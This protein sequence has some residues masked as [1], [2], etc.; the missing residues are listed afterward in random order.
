M[1]VRKRNGKLEAVNFNKTQQRIKKLLYGLKI[2]RDAATVIAQKVIQGLYDGVTTKE[3]DQ[4]AAETAASMIVQHPDYSY[5]GARIL[6]TSLKKEV[7]PT[8]SEATQ[9]IVDNYVNPKGKKQKLFN[10]T[11]LKFVETHKEVLDSAINHELDDAFTY[12]GVLTLMK[13]YLLKVNKVISETPQYMLMREAICVAGLNGGTIEEVI[14]TYNVLSERYYTHATPTL[15]NSG[16][17]KQQ[18]SSCFLLGME[19]SIK[20]IYKTLGNA[21]EISQHAGGIGIHVHNIRS[22]GEYIFGTMGTS[23][24]LV[25]MLKNYND[26]AVYVNQGGK[27]KGSFA[28]YLE[29]HHPDIFE[30]LELGLFNGKEEMRAR[31]LFFAIWGNDLFFER[32][33]NDGNYSL[34]PVVE[35]SDLI[36]LYGDEFR[37]R[38][39]YYESQGIAVRT[40]KAREIWHK[41]TDLLLER[42]MP[43]ILNKDQ[44]NEKSNQKNIGTIR[45]SNLCAEIIE[46]S[47]H[48]EHAV[49]NLASI[50]LSRFVENGKFD[51]EKL[52]EISNLATRNL[53]NVIDVNYYPTEETRISNLK[54]RPIGLGVQGLADVFAMLGFAFDSPEAKKLN[55]EIFETI[56]FGSLEASNQLAQETGLTYDGYDGSPI[57]QG[58]FQ[59]D[60]WQDRQV[61]PNGK[62]GFEIVSSKPIEL[63]GMWDFEALRENIKKY[64]VRNSLNIALMPTASTSQILGNNECFEP[65]TANIYARN[66]LAGQA[67]IINTH[68]VK[69]LE[70]LG[71]WNE[72]MSKQIIKEYGKLENI[73]SIPYELKQRYKTSYELKQRVLIDMAADRSPFVCQ[74]QS[75]NLYFVKP[76]TQIFDSA[77]LYGAAKGLITISYYCHQ[78]KAQKADSNL[79]NRDV[80]KPEEVKVEIIVDEEGCEMCGA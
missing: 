32:V 40:V 71:L 52:R 70:E 63:S 48:E 28:I 2:D 8:F 58:I 75:L 35:C 74:S 37:K 30:F 73:E 78:N 47:N 18:L 11:Y 9:Y 4:L 49:C 15:Y 51:F 64:G 43:Y 77:L 12:F 25:K 31:D 17:V 46:F 61:A 76:S 5:L 66:T 41:I 45:S 20:G 67:I 7:Q 54:R 39:E 23:D 29:P 10:D 80:V 59:F 26:T 27:R 60:M 50:A 22:A 3:L 79:G 55:K 72:T 19:D 13:S 57:S 38:Y 1:Q 16:L 53:N 33:N 36:D 62:G 6:L 24:G 44:A 56:Y 14:H 34:F 69:D 21:A 42:S 68:L 65:F